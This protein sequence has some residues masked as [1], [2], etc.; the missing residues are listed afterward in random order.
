MDLQT[1]TSEA[2][3]LSA[4]LDK[5]VQALRQA[6]VEFADA[7]HTYRRAK[8]L[9]YLDAPDGTVA[10]KEAHVYGM[11]GDLRHARDVADGVRTAALEAVRS[12]RTQLS[13]LQSLMAAHK[14]EAD[15]ARTGPR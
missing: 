8:S 2:V 1:L 6:G 11:V 13:A 7:E 15:F 10:E 9:A 14:S 3:R 5:G 12:R 4:L